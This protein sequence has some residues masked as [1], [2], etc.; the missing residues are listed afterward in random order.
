MYVPPAFREDRPEVL[1]ALIAA[2][3]LGLL[4]SH[5]AGGLMANPV[6]MLLADG[7][8]RAHLARANPQLA[9]LR[10]GVEVL[11]VFQ[12]PQGYVTPEWYPAKAEHGR[13]VPTWNYLTV[14][15]R[16]L[17]RM[18]EAA[19]WLRAQ[20][21]DLTAAQEAARPAPWA[22]SDAPE[23]FVAAQL[24]GICGVEIAVTALAGKWK[25]S[26]NRAAADRRGVIAGLESEGNPLAGFIPPPDEP[27][28]A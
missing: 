17:P 9:D 14:Q 4:V 19:D 8:L 26:Q 21:G 25:A 13:V 16:G 22:V 15:A 28:A 18:I 12:G 27:D 6:P 10:A 1:A 20:V 24:R 23:P 3:P 7:V 5:G 11:V 2:Y